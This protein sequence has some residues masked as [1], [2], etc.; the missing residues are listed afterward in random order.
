MLG[1]D[2][3]NSSKCPEVGAFLA[4]YQ[5]LI[6]RKLLLVS[7]P[8]RLMAEAVSPKSRRNAAAT[9]F[10]SSSSEIALGLMG[11]LRSIFE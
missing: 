4:S 5:F 7:L 2:L 8:I 9:I 11:K 3:A 10:A 1:E 6:A